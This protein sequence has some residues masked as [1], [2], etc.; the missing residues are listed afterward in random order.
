[1]INCIS[2]LMIDYKIGIFY[3]N[4]LLRN[5]DNISEGNVLVNQR[6]SNWYLLQTGWSQNQDIMS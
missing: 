6:L 4:W 1:M 2:G 5:Q 3:K